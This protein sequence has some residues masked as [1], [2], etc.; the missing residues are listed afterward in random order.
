MR[1]NQVTN[2]A[3]LTAFLSVPR[4]D[5]APEPLKALA[6]MDEHM[7][8]AVGFEDVRGRYLLAPMVLARLVQAL[9]P[10]PTDKALDIAC[11]TGYSAA[12]LA[13]LAASVRAVEPEP[14]LNAF[15]KK[16][17]A[18]A[19]AKNALLSKADLAT[20]YAKDAPYDVVLFNGAIPDAPEAIEA[21]LAEG[22]RMAAIVARGAES[23]AM[24]FEKAG[25]RIARRPI[26]DAAAPPLPDFAVET[27]FVF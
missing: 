19:Q 16:A 22:G 6:Y 24:L 7:P 4:E 12:I 2:P 13:R 21:Q 3:V 26:F 8:L 15:A 11:A 18:R 1:P 25:G 9:R 27:G 10:Q 17:L 5:F 14:A 23:K 20:G